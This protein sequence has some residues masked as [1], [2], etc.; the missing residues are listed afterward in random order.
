[1]GVKG[2]IIRFYFDF[3][4]PYAWLAW[5]PVN[6]IAKRTSGKIIPVPTLF[7]GLLNSHGQL[8]P[9]EIPAKRMW[10]IKDVSRRAAAQNLKCQPPPS[11]P[12]RP[13]L[14]LRV[15]SLPTL[16]D[17]ERCKVVGALLDACWSQGRD[18]SDSATIVSILN[19][20]GF[21]GAACVKQADEDEVKEM[22][23][24]QTNRAIK[25]GVFGVPTT[26]V[27]KEIFWGSE[28][29]TMQH[30]ESFIK[31][32]KDAVDPVVLEQWRNIKKTAQR[33]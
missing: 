3:I 28:S 12:F 20:L 19:S 31:T 5:R 15:A 13:L 11:H 29:D 30:I 25:E 10:L 24:D 22:L 1:M 21:D 7:A 26:Q 14:S 4:S 9:A 18:I 23:K 17:E 6:Q 16:S 27:A 2:P 32:G 33:R 8:G